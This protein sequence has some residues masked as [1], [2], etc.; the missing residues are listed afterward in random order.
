MQVPTWT[1]K[2]VDAIL[3]IFFKYKSE[4][5]G[6]IGII[7]CNDNQSLEQN[8][9]WHIFWEGDRKCQQNPS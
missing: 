9:V 8:I 7:L 6:K 3:K 5:N 1:K 4:V 2:L